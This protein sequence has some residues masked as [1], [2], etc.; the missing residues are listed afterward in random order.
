M[1]EKEQIKKNISIGGQGGSGITILRDLIIIQRKHYQETKPNDKRWPCPF[2][3]L[4]SKTN[5]QCIIHIK[6]EHPNIF[7][8]DKKLLAEFAYLDKIKTSTE[9]NDCT[10]E[11]NSQNQNLKKCAF[12]P[13][14]LSHKLFAGDKG[15]KI[16]YSRKHKDIDTTVDPSKDSNSSKEQS[17][18]LNQIL[19]RKIFQNS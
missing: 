10:N 12:C 5:L 2:C 9:G 8:A 1:T 13:P 7:C 19:S 6:K 3:L 16:H 11:S 17:Q 18:F 15:L 14:D 4:K